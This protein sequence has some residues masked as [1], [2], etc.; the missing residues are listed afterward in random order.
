M[1]NTNTNSETL[2]EQSVKGMLKSKVDIETSDIFFNYG[3]KTYLAQCAES[4]KRGYFFDGDYYLRRDAEDFL[5]IV[6]RPDITPQDLVDDFN[7]RT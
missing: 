2:L 1:K 6:D 7:N 3:A 5:E 4:A